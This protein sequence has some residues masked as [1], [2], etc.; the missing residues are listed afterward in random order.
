MGVEMPI[1][2]VSIEAYSASKKNMEV[3]TGKRI[4]HFPDIKGYG[5]Q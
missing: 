2:C 1:I 3:M 4:L 5:K